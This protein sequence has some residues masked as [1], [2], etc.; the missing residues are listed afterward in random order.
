[1]LEKLY[2]S[3]HEPFKNLMSQVADI[4]SKGDLMAVFTGRSSWKRD[5][6]LSRLRK[7]KKPPQFLVPELLPTCMKV[8]CHIL[9]WF[10]FPHSYHGIECSI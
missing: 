7:H 8:I 4:K 9:K 1:M 5:S 2:H 10:E 3:S 6:M